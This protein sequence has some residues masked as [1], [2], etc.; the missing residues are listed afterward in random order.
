MT[1]RSTRSQAAHLQCCPREHMTTGDCRRA[2]AT[3]VRDMNRR[4]LCRHNQ[5]TTTSELRE[6]NVVTRVERASF[7]GNIADHSGK[8]AD[9]R[10]P[11]RTLANEIHRS[12]TTLLR[13]VLLLDSSQFVQCVYNSTWL[14]SAT[15]GL[16][17]YLCQYVDDTVILDADDN[18]LT[19][20]QH[21]ALAVTVL[22]HHM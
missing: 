10:D 11:F 5:C 4:R 17:S 18:I 2:S 22:P 14:R 16:E 12:G 9:H 8:I 7:A 19:D 21:H 13:C 1:I 15:R 3:S 20:L 6:Q